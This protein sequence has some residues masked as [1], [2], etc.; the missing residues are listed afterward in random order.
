MDELMAVAD[1]AITKAGALTTTECLASG[2]PLVVYR[3]YPG[4]EVRNC[5]YFLE[6]GVA[7]RVD[8]LSGL[9]QKID[10]ILTDPERLAKMREKA[11]A[12]AHSDSSARIAK[13]L[14]DLVRK[15]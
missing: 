7:V 15:N 2:L 11:I 9:C 14:L 3:P 10:S 1:L 5:D 4:Q 8:Q 6:Q 13:Y 12:T